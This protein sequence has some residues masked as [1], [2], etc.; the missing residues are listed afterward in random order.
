MDREQGQQ[1]KGRWMP[2]RDLEVVFGRGIKKIQMLQNYYFESM[3][4]YTEI[5]RVSI[6]TG[7]RLK[8]FFESKICQTIELGP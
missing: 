3:I 4:K 6:V 1:V 5:Y 8:V 7:T 2:W